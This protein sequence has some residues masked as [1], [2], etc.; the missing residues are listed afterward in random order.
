V[1]GRRVSFG[2]PPAPVQG[3]SAGAV[4]V[5]GSGTA[6][7]TPA[8]RIVASESRFRAQPH[9]PDWMA[10]AARSMRHEILEVI[11]TRCVAAT[12]AWARL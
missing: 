2:D 5:F 10:V 7:G 12:G 9:G 11:C 8:T 1:P 4:R 3:Y 6:A